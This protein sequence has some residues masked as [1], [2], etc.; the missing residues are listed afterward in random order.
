MKE[1]LFQKAGKGKSPTLLFHL[2]GCCSLGCKLWT[3][4]VLMSLSFL[5][6]A[7]YGNLAFLPHTQLQILSP[8]D[9][10]SY[11]EFRARFSI[12]TEQE[13][14]ALRQQR[15]TE[16]T[17]GI[18]FFNL[19]IFQKQEIRMTPEFMAQFATVPFLT[20]FFS[21]LTI[22]KWKPAQ[23]T[24]A[25]VGTSPLISLQCLSAMGFNS[26]TGNCTVEHSL[27]FFKKKRYLELTKGKE[28]QNVN[29]L[30]S[31]FESAQQFGCA[32]LQYFTGTEN[33]PDE[34]KY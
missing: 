5:L 22:P 11:S 23:T 24:A 1:N 32:W 28:T 21:C 30:S 19:V 10:N 26:N 8:T 4:S 18:K 7:P 9:S 34:K 20:P 27:S 15:C 14:V 6:T 25:G 13:I 29:A 12:H 3:R 16:T 17:T 33:R 31:I 2:A